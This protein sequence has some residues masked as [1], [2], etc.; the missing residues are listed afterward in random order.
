MHVGA[1]SLELS[2]DG[3]S[4]VDEFELSSS[5]AGSSDDAHVDGVSLFTSSPGSFQ[6]HNRSGNSVVRDDDIPLCAGYGREK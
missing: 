2:T 4:S 5:S 6:V 1:G 3:S